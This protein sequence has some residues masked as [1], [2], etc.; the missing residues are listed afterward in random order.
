LLSGFESGSRLRLNQGMDMGK[1]PCSSELGDCSLQPFDPHADPRSCLDLD[2]LTELEL[3][4]FVERRCFVSV[5]LTNRL[6]RQ[7]SMLGLAA[8]SVTE[9][10]FSKQTICPSR[11]ARRRTLSTKYDGSNPNRATVGSSG[12]AT[13][14]P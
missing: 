4:C 14:V 13:G 3:S 10:S 7:S 6:W 1:D 2:V 5:C 9:S 12:H 8:S 11:L